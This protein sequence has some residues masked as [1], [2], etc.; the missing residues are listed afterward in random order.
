MWVSSSLLA[1]LSLL[2]HDMGMGSH[3]SR[4]RYFCS[5]RELKPAWREEVVLTKANAYRMFRTCAIG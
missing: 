5:G 3:N 2:P 1:W 4:V